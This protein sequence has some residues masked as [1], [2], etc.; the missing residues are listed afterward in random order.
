MN[1]LRIAVLKIT[2]IAFR[3]NSLFDLIVGK[4]GISFTKTV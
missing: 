3:Y 2:E 1:L 4:Q